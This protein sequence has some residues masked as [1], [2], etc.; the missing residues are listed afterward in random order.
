MCL[1]QRL[2]KQ[3]YNI[4]MMALNTLLSSLLPPLPPLTSTPASQTTP[5]FPP[6]PLYHTPLEDPYRQIQFSFSSRNNLQSANRE[7]FAAIV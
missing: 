5:L 1:R 7:K 2:R 3:T 4:S 6:L